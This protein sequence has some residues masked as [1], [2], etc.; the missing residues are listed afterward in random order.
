MERRC[1]PK[2]LIH[3][4][5]MRASPFTQVRRALAPGVFLLAAGMLWACDGGT[6][7]DPSVDPRDVASIAGDSIPGDTIPGDT[8]PGDTVPVPP[9]TIPGDTI[10][11]PPDTV[12][13]DTT[14]TPG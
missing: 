12:P 1:V 7:T 10:P 8:I 6:A 13:G 5:T 3:E 11:V 2:P 4:A 14:S 9:D